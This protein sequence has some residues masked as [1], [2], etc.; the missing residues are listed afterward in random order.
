MFAQTYTLKPEDAIQLRDEN[1]RSS[2]SRH[3]SRPILETLEAIMRENPFGQTFMTAGARVSEATQQG[4][5]P[6]FRVLILFLLQLY[7]RLYYSPT[8]RKALII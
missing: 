7:L 6:H 1:I 4:E 3:I 2:L 8:G 5:I